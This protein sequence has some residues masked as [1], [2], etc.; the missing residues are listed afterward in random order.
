MDT[1]DDKW[2]IEITLKAVFN[3]LK[4]TISEDL[5]R[6]LAYKPMREWSVLFESEILINAISLLKFP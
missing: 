4:K 1:P 3:E 2:V 5:N 6:D